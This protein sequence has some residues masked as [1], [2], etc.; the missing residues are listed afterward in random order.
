MTKLEEWLTDLETAE[1]LTNESLAE[2]SNATSRGLTYTLVTK[3]INSEKTWD[4]IKDLLRLKLCNA[5]VSHINL[6]LYGYTTVEEGIPSSLCS[7]I[8]TE[9]K[10]CNF[11]NDAAT[12]RIF[13]KGLRNA[14][15]LAERIYEKDP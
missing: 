13:I 3:A 4:E 7:L 5:N 10:G 9:A 6:V 12:I 1:D 14:Q 11:M 15:S 8:Q 2:L